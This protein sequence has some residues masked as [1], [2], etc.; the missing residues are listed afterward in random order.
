MSY[1]YTTIK[2]SL[3]DELADPRFLRAVR[4][5]LVADDARI[6]VQLEHHA[7]L[8]PVLAHQILFALLGVHIHGSDLQHFEAFAVLSDSLLGKEDRPGGLLLDDRTDDC[9]DQQSNKAADK[10]GKDIKAALH[11]GLNG[12][13]I[14]DGSCENRSARKLLCKALYPVPAHVRDMIMGR[15]RHQSTVIQQLDNF[16]IGKRCV[17]INGIDPFTNNEIGCGV[18]LGNDWNAANTFQIAFFVRTRPVIR[19]SAR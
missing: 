12:R 18:H 3:S 17:D 19:K 5:D 14:V 7:V 6:K 16:V 8:H 2:G 4:K 9:D 13:C 1:Y 11:Q 10:T 15:D